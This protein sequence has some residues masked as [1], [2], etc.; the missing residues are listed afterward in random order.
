MRST[1]ANG[2]SDHES[3]SSS[4]AS[5]PLSFAQDS[6]ATG[7]IQSMTLCAPLNSAFGGVQVVSEMTWAIC[8]LRPN[9]PSFE[10][11]TCRAKSFDVAC[12]TALNAVSWGTRF[13]C[14]RLMPASL[15]EF[16]SRHPPSD[17]LPCNGL[18]VL[19]P[20]PHEFMVPGNGFSLTN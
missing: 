11:S 1:R 4:H 7:N 17:H 14:A 10:L 5:V 3:R 8:R 20:P 6:I 12:Q 2:H 9:G 15:L 16:G 18:R 13:R 19:P